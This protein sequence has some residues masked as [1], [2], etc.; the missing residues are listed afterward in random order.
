MKLA[1]CLHALFEQVAILSK[2]PIYSMREEYLVSLFNQNPDTDLRLLE[3]VK[4][5]MMLKAVTLFDDFSSGRDVAS[6]VWQLFTRDT[7]R[8]VEQLFSNHV[9]PI[10]DTTRLQQV[11]LSLLGH[12]LGVRIQ[13]VRPISLDDDMMMSHYPSEGSEAYDAVTVIEDEVTGR[14]SVMT[15]D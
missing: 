4:V 3:A 12:T 11:E 13:V 14:Y 7:S 9:N 8:S 2:M 15:C 10:G 1:E 5:L 6:F